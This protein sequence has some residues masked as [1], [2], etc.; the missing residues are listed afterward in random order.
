MRQRYKKDME[1]G[2]IVEN[3]GKKLLEY[4]NSNFIDR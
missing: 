1:D 4:K 2:K 3:K